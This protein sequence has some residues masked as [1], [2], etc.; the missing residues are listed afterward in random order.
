MAYLALRPGPHP[1]ERVID[2]LWPDR[3]MAA[4]RNNLST[5]LVSL[6]RQ[7]EPAGARRG[8]V[9]VTTQADVGLNPDTVSTDLALFE[10]LLKRAA[11]SDN[12][13]Q[14]ADFLQRAADLYRGDLLPGNYQDWAVREAERLRA[15]LQ[16]ALQQLALDLEALGDIAGALQTAQRSAALDPYSEEKHCR[17]IRLYVLSGQMGLAKEA[18]GRFE[19]LLAEEF[20]ADLAPST[21]QRIAQI[22]KQPAAP[23]R[24]KNDLTAPSVPVRAEDA[25]FLSVAKEENRAPSTLPVALGRYFGR[26]AEIV[27]LARLLV[28]GKGLPLGPDAPESPCRLVTLTGPGGMG[29]TR[30]ALEFARQAGTRFNLWHGFVS[31]ADLTQA[32]QIPA[33]IA[34]TLKLAPDTSGDPLA[35]VCDFLNAQDS[36]DA[37]PLLILDN[38]EHLLP[39]EE[40]EEDTGEEAGGSPVVDCIQTLLAR[41]PGLL[42]L[43]TSRRRVAVRG[44]YLLALAPLPVPDAVSDASE[45]SDLARMLTVPSVRLYVDRAQAVR[46]D[47]GLTPTNAP[48]VAALC[49]QLEGSPLALELAAAW[50]RALP[51]R[52]MWER[53]TQGQDIPPGSYADLP[54]RHRTLS[55]ALEWSFRLLTPAQQRLF[56]RLSA[57]RGGWTPEAVEAVCAEP[58]ALFLLSALQEASLITATPEAEDEEQGRYTF[59][60]TVRAFSRRHLDAFGEAEVTDNAHAA[61]FL[62]LAEQAG[63]QLRGAE[64]A[65]WLA[66][67]EADH[68]N[69]RAALDRCLSAQSGMEQKEI[70]ARLVC[71]M[72]PFWNIRGHWAEARRYLEAAHVHAEAGL[73][74]PLHARLLN[75]RAGSARLVGDLARAQTL[76]EES[77]QSVAATGRPEGSFQ[78]A[79][80]S[81]VYRAP[82]G[83]I[84]AG[85]AIVR[86]ESGAG[87]GAGRCE[88]RGGR[89]APSRMAS[90]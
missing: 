74:A 86:G 21:R 19:R 53:L 17:L 34:G 44:E 8:S 6:R 4:G 22:F 39:R 49:R 88:R 69:I 71:A 83:P 14:R 89:A 38:L 57:F 81:G 64:Q 73:P 40:G 26:E 15:R 36:P 68:D 87:K 46:P 11:R 5:T 31:L 10:D 37:P 79:A 13:T 76:Y 9:L 32:A 48:A 52:K 65:R 80:Q 45:T 43:C 55:A 50:V 16:E 90:A 84:R 41:V 24:P 27:R 59:L 51:P 72:F 23:A 25:E 42:L 20:G 3:D 77:L 60:E 18:H 29:K 33:R 58:D 78:S 67:L 63:A 56:A 54:A 7:L 82:A 61:F 2:L 28:P 66:R 35:P 47:F 75:I 85:A 70:G 62:N 12:S 30:L 1:R